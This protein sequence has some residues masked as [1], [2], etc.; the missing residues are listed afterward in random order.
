MAALL[1]LHG[2]NSRISVTSIATF[3]ANTSTEIAYKQFRKDLHQIGVP[4]D[5]IQK[6]ED[7]I[8]EIFKS[9]GMV[10]SS[11]I[12]SSDTGDK[13]QVL[14]TAYEEY[15][16]ALYQL[17]F[18]DDMFPPK[19]KILRVLR[20]RGVVASNGAGEKGK[21]G[22]L[23]TAN[24]QTDNS[25]TKVLPSFRFSSRVNWFESSSEAA[26]LVPEAINE[27]NSPS[28]QIPASNIHSI[29]ELLFGK[30]SSTKII[31]EGKTF[32]LELSV[33]KLAVLR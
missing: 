12:G 6:N 22:Y 5:L 2:T 21:L 19:D 29:M 24:L 15:C 18:T 1:G 20:S 27:E 26:S 33:C 17:G 9:Q 7:E 32:V 11:Q 3:A 4:D 31:D 14:E 23:S 28:L 13:D 25:S 8:R 10:A 30:H 16:K